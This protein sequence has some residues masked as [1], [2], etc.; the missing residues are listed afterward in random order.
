MA[1]VTV[2]DCLDNVEN[3]FQLVL[4]AAKRARQLTLGAEPCVERANDK[5]TVLALREIAGGFVTSAILDEETPPV[6]VE[7]DEDTAQQALAGAESLFTDAPRA[8]TAE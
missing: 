5:P 4:V 3:R 6:G 2:E 1:R 8:G 7:A